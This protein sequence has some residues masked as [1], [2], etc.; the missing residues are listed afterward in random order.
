MEI[1]KNS[2]QTEEEGRRR[3]ARSVVEEERVERREERREER[4]DEGEEINV[5]SSSSEMSLSEVDSEEVAATRVLRSHSKR[6][7]AARVALRFPSELRKRRAAK[8]G[9]T[10]D[11]AVATKVSSAARGRSKRPGAYQFL[12][13]AKAYLAAGKGSE[14][15][16]SDPPYRS[17]RRLPLAADEADAEPSAAPERAATVEALAAKALLNVTMIQG[18]LKKGGNI[19]GTVLGQ[20]NKATQGVIEAVEGLRAI[21]PEEEQRRLRAENARLARELE[22]IRAEL[23]AFKDAYAESQRR[24]ATSAKEA[25]PELNLR[26]AME[27]VK[28]ELLESLG[29]MLN[30]RLEGLE[31]RLPPEPVT[32]PPLRTDKR[33]PPPPRPKGQAGA[34]RGAARPA[35]GPK[36][37]RSRAR[38]VVAPPP[39]LVQGAEGPPG[40]AATAEAGTSSGGVDLWSK[41]VGRKKKK[42]AQKSKAPVGAPATPAQPGKAQ[43]VPPSKAIRIVAPKTAAI[44][45]TLKKGATIASAEGQVSEATYAEVLTKARTSIRLR[46]FGL[47]T[48]KVRTTMTGSKLMEVG[49]TAPEEAANR[50]AAELAKVIG[51]WA[52]VTR[53]SKLVDL[54]V[55]GL[56]ET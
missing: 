50:L 7:P 37:Q 55:S 6:S 3:D 14:A 46:D 25:Q 16:G 31:T 44:T 11:P 26:G 30:A 35:Q 18:E 9:G 47:E 41:V 5:L 19:R 28:R 34:V 38:P 45:V 20:L 49:G 21:T 33:Q 22:L 48:V 10:V 13:A 4:R 54:K 53:P 17:H 15:E 8:E 42:K 27:E 24:P 52:D 29:G 23:K 36:A 39:P 40:V 1:N 56:D 2:N 43:R 51:A 32:R 12:D